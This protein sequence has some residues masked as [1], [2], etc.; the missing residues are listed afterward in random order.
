M[1]GPPPD[2]DKQF[3][4]EMI[5]FLLR[6]KGH[7]EEES[8]AKHARPRA[9]PSSI[10]V[11]S[12]DY[13]RSLRSCFDVFNTGF[14]SQDGCLRHACLGPECCASIEVCEQKMQ[15]A[16]L[17]L[18][19]SAMPVLPSTGKWTKTGPC[20]DWFLLAFLF[21]WFKGILSMSCAPLKLEDVAAPEA[22]EQY[23]STDFD[24]AKVA[25]VRYKRM[26]D[27]LLSEYC[28]LAVTVFAVVFEQLRILCS[29]F[30]YI[31]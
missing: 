7:H 3:A 13:E 27:M 16:L 8:G 10:G 6:A 1:P 21:G 17:S 9:R 5:D 31:S 15:K 22:D 28:R 23:C 4:A 19:L 26:R 18:P 24:W 29:Y 30:L 11:A 20:N 25:G 14:D 2:Q 12:K